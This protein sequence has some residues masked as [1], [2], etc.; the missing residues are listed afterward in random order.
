M[1]HFAELDFENIVIRTVVVDN[2]KIT[3]ENGNESEKMGVKYL[4]GIF[5]GRWKQT[6]YNNNFRGVFAHPGFFYDEERDVF[7]EPDNE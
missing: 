4:K 2:D 6:S 1:A 7:V 3:D 5:G